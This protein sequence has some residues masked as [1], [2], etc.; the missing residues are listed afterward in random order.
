MFMCKFALIVLEVEMVYVV[1]VPGIDPIV[2]LTF[3]SSF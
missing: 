2:I 3:C 1:N